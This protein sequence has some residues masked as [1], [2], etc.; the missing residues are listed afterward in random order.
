[1]KK[2]YLLFAA[3][4]ATAVQIDG[5]KIIGQFPVE[6]SIE[7]DNFGL[8]MAEGNELKACVDEVL[9]KLS[10]E[11]KLA[12]IESQWLGDGAGVPVIDLN[13]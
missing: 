13:Q 11:G 1:M 4:F 7:P 8:L 2:F 12:E 3:L 9:L 5:G 6:A 10:E